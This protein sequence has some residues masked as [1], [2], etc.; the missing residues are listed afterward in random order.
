M[1]GDVLFTAPLVAVNVA[2]PLLKEIQSEL[3]EDGRVFTFLCGHDS[4][5]G[6]VLAAMEAED[7][8][9]PD[10]IEGKTPIG[11]KLVFS[12]WKGT[13]GAEYISVDLVYQTTD[14]LKDL[15]L[16]NDSNPP[17]I[18]AL[19]FEGLQPNSDGLYAASD[20]E[21]RIQEA[22][23]EYDTVARSSALMK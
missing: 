7:Y 3:G 17:G 13:E 10:S 18:Y 4:N 19:S 20:I 22:V 2:N 21:G 11:G 8:D 9:L 16:L 6:S 1:Y 15:T 5:I 23:D 14:Q 12:R